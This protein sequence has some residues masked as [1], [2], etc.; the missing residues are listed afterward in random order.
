[1]PRVF[2]KVVGFSTVERH[3]LNTLFRLSEDR[4]PAYA[5]WLPG[6]AEPPHLLLL[7]GSSPETRVELETPEAASARLI[8]V[9][10][11]APPTS[12]RVFTRPITWHEVIEAMDQ[13]VAPAPAKA[14]A[15][16]PSDFDLDLG[17]DDSGA[18]TL[19]PE[20]E[21]P[22]PRALIVST[23]REQRLYLRAR[24]ALAGM[25][26]VD[27]AQNAAEALEMARLL[28]YCLALV[29]HH[30]VAVDGWP[31]VKALRASQ[32][33]PYVILAKD[34]ATLMDRWRA[35]MFGADTLL[36]KPIEPGALQGVLDRVVATSHAAA[37][38]D[39][40]AQ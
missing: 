4:E 25:T 14:Q 15:N 32:A 1:M 17:G 39:L 28:P 5:L 2:V 27:E 20:P 23:D 38:P 7:D 26:A 34:G 19:P 10:P 40:V 12:A 6:A 24:L 21:P 37:V 33:K 36:D 35:W 9:G 22:Q 11:E 30:P 18:A 13:L 29:D 8:W 3:A 16:A 31:L